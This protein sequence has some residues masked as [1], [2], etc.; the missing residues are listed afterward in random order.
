MAKLGVTLDPNAIEPGMDF[1]PIPAPEVYA[2]IIESE[3]EPAKTGRGQ[4][5]KL[6]WKVMD[7]A[8]EFAGRQ[9][10][11]DINFLHQSAQAQLIGQQQI[12]AICEAVGY[13][14]HLDDSEV[15]HH[16]P[17]RVGLKITQDKG[18]SPKNEV[19][20]VKPVNPQAPQGK[21]AAS[22]SSNA[23]PA[24]NGEQGHT[25]AQSAPPAQTASP[26]AK[27]TGDRPW[28]RSAA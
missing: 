10:W 15:L 2:R 14:G 19:R 5:L 7:D 8:A 21:P 11:Q 1:E 16:T 6:T 27:P 9:F 24:A 26:P 25:S 13:A 3:V 17:C 4:I 18:Y 23:S 20:F 22:Q 28:N 12:R